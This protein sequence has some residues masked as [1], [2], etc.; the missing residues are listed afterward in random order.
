VDPKWILFSTALQS[1]HDLAKSTRIL[2]SFWRQIE[3]EQ[4]MEKSF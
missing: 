2:G 3:G 1:E 4:F